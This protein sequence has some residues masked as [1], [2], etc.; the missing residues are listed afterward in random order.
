MRSFRFPRSAILLMT[1][2]FVATMFAIDQGRN[3]QDLRSGDTHF[4]TAW[5][6]LYGLF[7]FL[8][9]LVSSLGAIGYLVLFA[10]RRSGAQRFLNIR[11]WV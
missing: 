7:V 1:V 11:T 9:V 4:E 2:I 10:L 3:I 8:G 5:T 6:G